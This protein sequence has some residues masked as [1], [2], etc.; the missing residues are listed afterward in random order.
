MDPNHIRYQVNDF[1]RASEALIGSAQVQE[2]LTDLE[3]EIVH[4]SIRELVQQI[5]TLVSKPSMDN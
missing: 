1:A 5:D 2:R 3:C 4:Q